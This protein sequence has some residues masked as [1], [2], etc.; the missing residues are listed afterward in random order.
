MWAL[1]VGE[2]GRNVADRDKWDLK[3]Q[4]E[5]RHLLVPRN[6]DPS[7]FL[8]VGAKPNQSKRRPRRSPCPYGIGLFQRAV[9]RSRDRLNSLA[10]DLPAPPRSRGTAILGC[11]LPALSTAVT[12]YRVSPD[13]TLDIAD[14]S[15]RAGPLAGIGNPRLRAHSHLHLRA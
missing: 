12:S 9:E 8:D 11:L 5:I 13:L 10:P 6:R 3:R 14:H 1:G 7:A 2:P 4:A 15:D